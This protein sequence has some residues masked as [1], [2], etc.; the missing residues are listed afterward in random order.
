MTARAQHQGTL[1]AVFYSQQAFFLGRLG[2]TV[3]RTGL[4]AC[5][6]KIVTGLCLLVPSSNE[7]A[8]QHQGYQVVPNVNGVQLQRA[9][10]EDITTRMGGY[11]EPDPG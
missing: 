4:S 8:H 7:A 3:Y 10:F 6:Y 2:G 1:V 11:H 5:K 9:A